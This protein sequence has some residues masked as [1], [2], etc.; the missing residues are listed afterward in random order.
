MVQDWNRVTFAL[1]NRQSYVEWWAMSYYRLD[2]QES[3]A[4]GAL[5]E[6][7][8]LADGSPWDFAIPTDAGQD[9]GDFQLHGGPVVS[10]TPAASTGSAELV[11]IYRGTE[12]AVRADAVRR[13]LNEA[14]DQWWSDGRVPA[15]GLLRDGLLVLEAGGALDEAQRTLLL[16]A[17]LLRRRGILTAL[18]HQPDPER[19]ASILLEAVTFQPPLVSAEELANLVRADPH[20]SEWAPIL[21]QDLRVKLA[22]AG[23]DATAG[24][25]ALATLTGQEI[26][27]PPAAEQVTITDEDESS[28][29]GW[30]RWLLLAL[31]AGGI[32]SYAIWQQQSEKPGNVVTVAAAYSPLSTPD[33]Q[34]AQT[35]PLPPFAIDRTEVTNASYR[36]CVEDGACLPPAST[37]SA[38]RPDYFVNSAYDDYPVVHVSWSAARAYCEWGGMRLPGAAEWEAAAGFA[39]A[40]KRIY[41]YPWGDQFESQFVVSAD[42]GF[43]DTAPVGARSPAGDSPLGAADMAGNVAEWTETNGESDAAVALVKGGSYLDGQ[44][45]LAVAAFQ[46]LDK[47]STHPWLGFRCA[48]SAQ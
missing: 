31:L 35:A 8:A 4:S 9:V 33:A 11:N 34:G 32:V 30:W 3:N 17:A 38:L 23:S 25:A 48:R 20:S 12:G 7:S 46:T 14:L 22:I 24:R 43:L 39:P 18:R 40:T 19:T 29:W 5:Y 1:G 21:T 13:Q 16:R 15:S 41:R 6:V 44:D 37:A 42:G 45:G 26:L 2:D 47:N 10:K 28:G 36:R 27:T